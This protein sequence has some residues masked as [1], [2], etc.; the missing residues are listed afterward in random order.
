MKT[1]VIGIDGACMDL[2]KQYANEGKLPTF[3]KLMKEGSY[4]NLES[5]TPPLTIPAWNCIGSGKNPGKLGC[6]S[7]VQK[8]KDGYNFRI[9]S[10][11]VKRETNMWDILSDQGKEI[12]IFNAPNIV[13]AYKINGVMVAG[14]LCP[15]EEKR[16]YPINLR[17]KLYRMGYDENKDGVEFI[18]ISDDERSKKLKDMTEKHCKI[19]SHFIEGS[20][21]FGFVVL[22]ELDGIQHR[23]W[24]KKDLLLEHYQN[25]DRK[26][27]EILDKLNEIDDEINVIIVSDHGFGPNNRMFLVNEWLLH[28]GLLE[29]KKESTFMLVNT[30]IRLVKGPNI[31]KIIRLLVKIPILLPIY[32]RLYLNAVRTPLL[33]KKSKAFSYGNWGTIY[34]NRDIVKE[35]EYE[36]LRN[37]IIGG[38]NKISVK[39][40]RK[41]ELYHGEYLEIAPDIIIQIDDYVNSVSGKVG[42]NKEFMEGFPQDG[43][44]R[45]NNGTF[46]AWGPDIKKHF[47]IDA[48]IFDICPT[49]LHIFGMPIPEDID[50]RVLK[51]IFTGSMAM[52]EIKYKKVGESEKIIRRVNALK[53][54]GGI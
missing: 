39:A 42:Y 50:G 17:D 54:F 43:Y 6:F 7:F 10:S 13:T 27:S 22:T 45:K 51:E 41:E 11:Q 28:R 52:K 1:L 23:F 35:D 30:I 15:F 53:Q 49:I 48:T 47:E 29:V 4:G 19:I 33:W 3:D 32:R 18:V 9:Y 38:L 24:K 46:I 36:Q 37:E 16:T 44:H 20:W 5:V 21:D 40:Y 34:I 8:D 14:F 31:L 12:F 26:L 25:M 2:I